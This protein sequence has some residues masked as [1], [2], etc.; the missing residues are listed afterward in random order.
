MNPDI[1][2]PMLIPAVTSKL[3][4]NLKLTITRQ[5]GQDLWDIKLILETFKNELGFLEKLSLT[6]AADKDKFEFNTTSRTCLHTTQGESKFSCVF[7]H[8]KRKPQQCKTVTK[9]ETR[10]RILRKSGKC[11]LYLRDRHV[12]RY[13]TQIFTCFKCQGKHHISI[14]DEKKRTRDHSSKRNTN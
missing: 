14:C 7:C 12:L 11:F 8:Q 5:F 3:P 1:Y 6:K 9:I 2:G 4:E 10:K 13:Y